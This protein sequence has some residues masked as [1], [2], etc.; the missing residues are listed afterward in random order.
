MAYVAVDFDGTL[1][2]GN[3]LV[4]MLKVGL[5]QFPLHRRLRIYKGMSQAAI[6]N[7]RKG[8]YV[9]RTELFRAFAQGFRGLTRGEVE[10]FFVRLVDH[11]VEQL[12][13]EI[14]E[15]IQSHHQ[16]GDRVILLSGAL[17]PFLELFVART[18]APIDEV[19]GT[20]LLFEGEICTGEIGVINHGEEK[21]RHFQAWLQETEVKE[22][23]AY[24][25]SASDLPLFEFVSRPVV[26]R[27]K[28]E[29]RTHVEERGWP[30]IQ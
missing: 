29:F 9:V 14:L 10:A 15:R 1:F 5:T 3:P 16:S 30:I 17:H 25:D 28:A 22:T 26:V 23:W 20:E 27:P 4:L 24:A 12:D 2:Q 13:R 6:I 21:V 11:G 19:R 18:G 8:S 7:Y